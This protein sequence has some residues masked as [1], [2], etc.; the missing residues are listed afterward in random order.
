MT[1]RDQV[2][3]VIRYKPWILNKINETYLTS[4]LNHIDLLSHYFILS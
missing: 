2:E 3:K 1:F 4:P